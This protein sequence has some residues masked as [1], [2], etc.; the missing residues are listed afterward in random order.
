V[1]HDAY[2]KDL[3]LRFSYS[4]GPAETKAALALIERGVVRAENL[5][6]HRF[7]LEKAAEAFRFA[8]RGGEALK[9][10]VTL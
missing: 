2:F 1:P 10:I 3:T 9:V 7:P 8:E 4:C 5:V 6:T